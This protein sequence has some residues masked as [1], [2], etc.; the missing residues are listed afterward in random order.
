MG[1]FVAV[2]WLDFAVREGDYDFSL[3]FGGSVDLDCFGVK[4][5][6][7]CARWIFESVSKKTT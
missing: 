4:M 6:K 3:V 5:F 2:G 7:K 1:R